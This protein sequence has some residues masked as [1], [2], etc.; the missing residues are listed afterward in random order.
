MME[1]PDF[2]PTESAVAHHEIPR[3]SA[4]FHS[5]GLSVC[6]VQRGG[7]TGDA[8]WFSINHSRTAAHQSRSGLVCRTGAAV[9]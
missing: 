3:V 6:R 1:H 5:F 2:I 7:R 4:V 9:A 8:I